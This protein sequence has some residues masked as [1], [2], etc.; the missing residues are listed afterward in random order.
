MATEIGT[1]ETQEKNGH[2]TD[3]PRLRPNIKEMADVVL[4]VGVSGHL[5]PSLYWPGEVLIQMWSEGVM[6]GLDG[7]RILKDLVGSH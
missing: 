4:I 2:L 6:E 3:E 1:E 7:R 5:N